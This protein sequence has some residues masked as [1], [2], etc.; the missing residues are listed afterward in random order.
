MKNGYL[1][2]MITGAIAGTGAGISAIF[3]QTLLVI[4]GLVTPAFLEALPY[5]VTVHIGFNM[6]FGIAFGIIYTR[7]YDVIPC[8]GIK[9]GL[10]YG[11]I[12]YVTQD[13]WPASY[14]LANGN[15]P[16]SSGF[17]FSGIFVSV[18]YGF[19]QGVL[20]EGPKY[21]GKIEDN[22]KG[23]MI[24]GAIA[25]FIGGI[26]AFI[27][28]FMNAIVMKIPY[29]WTWPHYSPITSIVNLAATE[30]VLMVIWGAVFSI[31]FILFFIRI[32]GK[33]AMKGLYFGLILCLLCVLRTCS[34]G[35]PYAA[36]YNTLVMSVITY[37]FM[38]I[39]YGIVLGALYKPPK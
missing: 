8:K 30:I 37:S 3:P 38:F 16:T 2:G 26:V 17:L 5:A 28:Q 31:L 34:W 6:I 21:L 9:K 12:L 22:I 23:G 10:V 39:I 7:F 35:I 36:I 29:Y 19:L 13:L 15:F 1:A 24:V 11:L 25:G 4:L 14:Y 20:Y 32:P 33:G 18:T 27:L